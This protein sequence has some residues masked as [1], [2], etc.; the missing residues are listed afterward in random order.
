MERR[1]MAKKNEYYRLDR[2]LKENA[3]YNMI[4]GERSNGKTYACLEYGLKEYIKNGYQMAIIRRYED[5]FRNKRG[6]TMFDGL[7]NNGLIKQLTKGEYTD[8]LYE[9]KMWYLCY[10]DAELKKKISELLIFRKMLLILIF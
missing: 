9:S 2:I 1:N 3:V 6:Q 4:I 10:Y 7:V 8:V 5:D